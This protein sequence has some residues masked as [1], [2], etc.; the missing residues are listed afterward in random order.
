MSE[1]PG[2]G[3]YS[4]EEINSFGKNAYKVSIRGKP[5]DEKLSDAPGPG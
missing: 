5:K 4:N 1:L 3:N 2:P